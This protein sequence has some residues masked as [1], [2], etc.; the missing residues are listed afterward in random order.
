MREQIMSTY[1]KKARDFPKPRT[2]NNTINYHEKLYR[3]M[4]PSA[5]IEDFGTFLHVSQKIECSGI[6]RYVSRPAFEM[7]RCRHA[8]HGL[9]ESRAAVA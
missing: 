9:V 5:L 2:S 8:A 7:E 3:D 4:N 6:F 1:N